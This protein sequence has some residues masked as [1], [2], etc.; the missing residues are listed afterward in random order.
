MNRRKISSL[1]F[2]ILFLLYV[3]MIMPN[4]LADP[5]VVIGAPHENLFLR[6]FLLTIFFLFATFVEF[7]F[8]KKV[9]F[10]KR[11]LLQGDFKIFLRINVITYP[12]TQILVYIVYLYLSLFFWINVLLIEIVVVIIEWRLLK[13]EISKNTENPISSRFILM[14]SI[15]AN[16]ISFLIGLIA[17][18]P[19][20]YF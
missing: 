2:M 9:M 3:F 10:N 18:L 8:F 15:S 14:G 19:Q 20:F 13:I 5:V 6:L 17:Y 12:L 4:V 1:W 16:F 7:L 11:S